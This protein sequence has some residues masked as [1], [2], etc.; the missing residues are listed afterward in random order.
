M[1][2]TGQMMCPDG[3]GSEYYTD[4]SPCTFTR[5]L[6]ATCSEVDDV[7]YI[8]VQSNEMPNHCF[9]AINDN[10]LSTNAGDFEVIFNRD[11]S[12]MENVSSEDVD[13]E[14]KATELLCDISRTKPD[15][16]LDGTEYT[17]YTDSVANS[18]PTPPSQLN[19][20]SGIAISGAM[21]FNALASGNQDAV[22]NEWVTL[23]E[24]LTHP[25]PYGEYHYHMWSPCYKKGNG[26]ASTTVA[27]DMCKDNMACHLD[28][29]TYAINA[30]FTDTST[31]GEIIGVTKDGHLIYGP[32]NSNGE[33]WSCDEHDICNGTFIDGNYVYVSTTTFPYILGC[34][35][36][37]P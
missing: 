20:A 14:T 25:T 18:V 9:Q 34:Y 22:E 11:V 35:G 17:E 30:A 24:C 19:T 26:W 32:Y 5:K 27:P 2:C 4:D 33:L 37:G 36:P 7:V 6:C 23:D 29:M 31:Y 15:N 21:I 3:S 1:S 13:S 8:R 12:G 28:P 16:M 10:P